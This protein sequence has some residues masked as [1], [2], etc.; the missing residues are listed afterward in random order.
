MIDPLNRTPNF[1]V[2]F[3]QALSLLHADCQRVIIADNMAL[4][5]KFTYLE[6]KLG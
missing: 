5:G 4:L 2:V 6:G 3:P 1:L